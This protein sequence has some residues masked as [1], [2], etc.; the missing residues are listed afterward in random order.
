MSAALRKFL[1]F[2][3]TTGQTGAFEF[4]NRS[5][6]ILRSAETGVGIDD[7]RNFHRFAT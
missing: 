3:V 2:D 4:S 6:D 7:R 1:I 5:P